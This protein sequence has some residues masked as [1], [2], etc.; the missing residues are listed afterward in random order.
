MCRGLM[1]L[2]EENL[3][4][5]SDKKD[6]MIVKTNKLINAIENLTLSET[7]LI[8]LAIIGARESGG[9]ES[10][11]RL[12]VSAKSYA[13]TFNTT[14]ENAYKILLEAEERLFE[15]KFY[16]LEDGEKVKSRWVNEVKYKK[17]SPS[18]EIALSKA[19][20]NEITNIDGYERFFTTYRLAQTCDFKSIY[21]L[22][23]YEL[24]NSWAK[25]KK[26]P[27]YEL[28]VFRKL[29]GIKENEY[30]RMANFKARV[31]DIAIREINHNTD[32]KVGYKQYKKGRKI[33]GF[34][35]DIKPKNP[36]QFQRKKISIAE[37]L[38]LSQT[39]VK[40][41]YPGESERDAIR[42]VMEHKDDNGNSVYYIEATKE[43]WE[44]HRNSKKQLTN[45]IERESLKQKYKKIGNTLV[46]DA[47]IYKYKD[48]GETYS[49]AKERIEKE[50]SLQLE[51]NLNK[52]QDD[53]RPL[54]EILNIK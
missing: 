13:E 28:D 19:V 43:D 12:T 29:L 21:S 27:V 37:A 3:D 2:N 18:L 11:Q 46:D 15:Q 38:E 26:T 36:I 49:Q 44:A 32:V 48:T 33:V 51:L 5:K 8:Q 7:R 31:L 14:I 42:R 20:I 25:N 53:D 50:L 9:L 17:G 34:S 54:W 30:Q 47:Y 45:K 40:G 1:F 35:F 52:T 6:C 39:V 22:R 10:N 24:L 23:L 41:S 4:E 16:Y